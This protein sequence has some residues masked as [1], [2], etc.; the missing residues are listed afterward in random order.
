MR[1]RENPERMAALLAERDGSG[2]SWAELSRHCGLPAR[3]LRWWHERFKRNPAPR[4]SSPSFVAVE[5]TDPVRV[6]P[7]SIEITT[8][9]GYRVAV[10]PGFAADHLRRLLQVLAAGC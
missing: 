10:P 9:A 3:K 1:R 7:G 8:P 4:K 2:W 5:V 6:P